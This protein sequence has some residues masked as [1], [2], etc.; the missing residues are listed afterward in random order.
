MYKINPP[1]MQQHLLNRLSILTLILCF[2]FSCKQEQKKNDTKPL[3]FT[4]MQN[5]GI[6]FANNI[7]N[8]KDFNIFSYRNFY[9]GGGSA[10]GDINNDGLADV[11]F[12]ANMGANKLYLNKGNWN[13]EDISQKAGI[14]EQRDWSTG[15][16]FVDINNDN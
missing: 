14:E 13:F 3:L 1:L 16:V 15:V 6:D 10:I 7:H 8:T 9:N 5:T 2:V 11:F 4:A 12:T